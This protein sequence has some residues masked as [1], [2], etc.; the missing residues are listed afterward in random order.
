MFKKKLYLLIL[1]FILL[2]YIEIITFNEEILFFLIFVTILN[3]VLRLYSV[4]LKIYLDTMTELIFKEF[5]I[6]ISNKIISLNLIKYYAKNL[7]LLT[8]DLESI[9]IY[10]YLKMN[11]LV[12]HYQRDLLKL[13]LLII[14]KKLKLLLLEMNYLLKYINLYKVMFFIKE[15]KFKLLRNN[16]DLKNKLY[17]N[18]LINLETTNIFFKNI[19]ILTSQEKNDNVITTNDLIEV[20]FYLKVLDKK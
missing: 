4:S 18:K 6:L 9:I 10:I 7:V 1:I 16:L 20:L 11:S 14:N 19:L 13:L 17:S 15:F 8:S 3:V 12:S 2:I 5:I